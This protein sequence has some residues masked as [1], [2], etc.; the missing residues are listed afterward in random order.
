MNSFMMSG[1][2]DLYIERMNV[3]FD[4]DSPEDYTTFTSETVGPLRKVHYGKMERVFRD[5][6]PFVQ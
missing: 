1:F 3:S 2:K 6:G 4:F 5:T